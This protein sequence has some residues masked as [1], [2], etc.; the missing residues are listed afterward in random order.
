MEMGS[1]FLAGSIM[2]NFLLGAV[3]VSAMAFVSVPAADAQLIS[4]VYT[5]DQQAMLQP[6]QFYAWGGRNYCWYPDGWHGPGYY[7][8]GYRYRR[9]YG[10]GGGFGWHG[11]GGGGYRS[12]YHGGGYR[13][14][15]HGGG[16][17]GA[18]HGGGYHGGGGHG[19]YHGGG[20]HS[21]GGHG[22]GS[23]GGHHH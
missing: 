5:S 15:Y 6:V 23:H 4:G 16:Y 21:G 9:G 20:G 19:G 7:W 11:W 17:H 13:G 14:G 12:G 22:G 2:R 18:G 1:I 8:C 3:A 10:W